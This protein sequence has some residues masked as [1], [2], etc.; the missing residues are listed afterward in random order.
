MEWGGRARTTR[1]LLGF[2]GERKK[3]RVNNEV[4]IMRCPTTW[5]GP[6]LVGGGG[7]LVGNVDSSAGTGIGY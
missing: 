7:A 1:E 4:S 2:V 3:T 6:P 5:L